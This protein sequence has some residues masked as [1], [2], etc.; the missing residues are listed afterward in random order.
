MTTQNK[1]NTF[2]AVLFVVIVSFLLWATNPSDAIKDCEKV[3]KA[4][5]VRFWIKS[6]KV[7]L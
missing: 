3:N 6:R 7:L 1:N 5:F 2:H 4:E